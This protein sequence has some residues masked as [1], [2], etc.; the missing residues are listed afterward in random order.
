MSRGGTFPAACAIAIARSTD[1]GRTFLDPVRVSEDNWKID[2]C[3]DDGPSMTIDADGAVQ[4]A[5]P[6]LVSDPDGPRMA[7][8]QSTS[9]DGGATFSPRVRVDAAAGGPAHPRIASASGGGQ[10]AIVWDELAEGTRRVMFRGA[11]APSGHAVSAGRIASYPDCGARR[12]VPGRLD[13]PVRGTIGHPGAA[14][15]LSS[16]GLSPGEPDTQSE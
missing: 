13:R 11:G 9:R 16:A 10:A 8:F 6:T 1:G 7:I 2:A 12:R 14:R 15:P 3:P 4:V 5:W